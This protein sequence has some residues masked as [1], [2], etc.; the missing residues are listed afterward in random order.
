ML[1]VVFGI[2]VCSIHRADQPAHRVREC[3]QNPQSRA[4]LNDRVFGIQFLRFD[5]PCGA[6]AHWLQLARLTVSF[7][8]V[9]SANC[10]KEGVYLADAGSVR[11]WSHVGGPRWST[12]PKI[13]LLSR[14]NAF[15][16][17]L[18][19]ICLLAISLVHTSLAAGDKENKEFLDKKVKEFREKCQK[20]GAE[21]LNCRADLSPKKCK[22]LV[23]G[24]DPAAWA[25]CVYSCGSEGIYSKTFGECSN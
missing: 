11:D 24:S 2:G 7:S 19:L 6:C 10:D 9:D 21:F 23:Y 13:G 17:T 1:L 22:S 4:R 5:R 12:E 14:R 3:P 16:K 18:K 8:P 15:L 25:R 20:K